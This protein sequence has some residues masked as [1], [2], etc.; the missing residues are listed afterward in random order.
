MTDWLRER[1]EEELV[2]ERS[3][4]VGERIERVMER[5]Q[6]DVPAGDR[7]ETLVIWTDLHTAFTA[8]G[9]T[10]YFSRRLFERMPHDDAVALV[11][12]HE[13]AHHRLHHIPAARRWGKL[14]P[15][16]AVIAI[17]QKKICGPADEHEADLLAVELCL[18]AGYDLDRCLAALE[19]LRDISFDY[20]DVDGVLGGPTRRTHHPIDQRIAAARAHASEMQRGHRLEGSLRAERDRQRRRR[21]LAVAGGAVAI[22][23]IIV[24]RR[25]P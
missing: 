10:I 15:L 24:L 19:I 16:G 20:G 12:A 17:V 11:I 21:T 22:A 6:R 4:W 5:L 25:R 13:I 9:R 7:L 1:I 23:A 18:D 3:G 14:L 8:P 2:V